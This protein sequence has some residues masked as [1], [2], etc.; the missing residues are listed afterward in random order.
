MDKPQQVR[1]EETRTRILE[2]ALDLFARDG[3]DATGVAQICQRCGMSKGAFYHH[4]PSKQAVFLVLLEEWLATLEKEMRE[5]AERSSSVPEALRQMV[6]RMQGVMQVADGRLSF[7]LEFWTQARKDPQVWERTIQPFRQYQ[8][9]F[10]LLIQRGIDEG[11][12]RPVDADLVSHA[13]VS[14]AVGLL[15]Q[16]VVDPAVTRWEEVTA[17]AV[18]FFIQAMLR[19]DS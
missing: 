10:A 18:E 8:R 5:A 13:L 17:Q 9:L 3:Y 4:F 19:R 12:F 15:L 1:S 7:F 14:M 6:S 16:G 2:A 11:S